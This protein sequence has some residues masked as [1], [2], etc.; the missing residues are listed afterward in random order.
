MALH[1]L[2]LSS[3]THIVIDMGDRHRSK[4]GRTRGGRVVEEILLVV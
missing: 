1:V 4:N 3:L 2:V